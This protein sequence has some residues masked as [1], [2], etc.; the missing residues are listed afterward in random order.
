MTGNWTAIGLSR[1][2][3]P[4]G[5]MQGHW[6]GADIA[7]WRSASGR[8][9]AWKDRCPHRGMRLSHG[10]VRGETLACIYHGWVY[11]TEGSCR[12]IPAHPA[13]QPPATIKAEVYQAREQDGVIWIAA[14]ADPQGPAQLAGMIGLRSLTVRA[15]P[16][17][18]AEC[19]PEFAAT[20]D[21]ILRGLVGIG[22]AETDL[23]L[24]LQPK[25]GGTGVHALVRA[26][27]DGLKVSRWLE[28][29]RRRVEQ[30]VS[31]W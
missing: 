22:E 27:A 16:Q 13:M 3:E 14:Q 28:S 11:G 5:V 6:Q 29:W 21:G 19:S 20:S 7:V 24:V 25:P 23:C 30:G 2:L 9:S 15:S 1:D 17:R 26:G 10:F 18:L 8:L 12:H 31:A 4:C